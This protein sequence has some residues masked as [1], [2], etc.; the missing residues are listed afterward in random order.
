[1]L[2][3]TGPLW[4][5]DLMSTYTVEDMSFK[6]IDAGDMLDLLSGN[7]VSGSSHDR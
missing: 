6:P 2:N 1:M 5:Q 3:P 7:N 4:L